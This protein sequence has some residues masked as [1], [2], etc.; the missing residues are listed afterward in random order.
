MR[1]SSPIW[2]FLGIILLIF[3]GQCKEPEEDWSFC[4]GCPIESWTG[5]Y[6]GSGSY[7]E[8]A[9][10]SIVDGVDVQLTIEN[11]SANQFNIQVLSPDY[12]SQSFYSSKS[13]SNYYFD[14]AG[15][16][17]SIHLSLYQ[18]SDG[19]KINGV[20]KKYH[21]EW[22]HEP[23]TSYQILIPDHTLS[24]EVYNYQ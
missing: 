13:D 14:L 16:N 7:Y 23:D 20:A 4:E 3:L 1:I 22:V 17:N 24:F 9:T 8:E 11:P 6:S 2:G 5:D 21:W 10:N 15:E 19:Y 12:Y 18:R